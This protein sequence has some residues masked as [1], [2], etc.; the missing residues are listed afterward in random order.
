M[1]AKVIVNDALAGDDQAQRCLDAGL[2]QIVA[3]YVAGDAD[4]REAILALAEAGQPV[5]LFAVVKRPRGTW[6]WQDAYK[7]ADTRPSGGPGSG[8]STTTGRG[9]PPCRSS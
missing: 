4:A 8:A 7:V 9:R 2:A 3:D 1:L 5:E 6:R